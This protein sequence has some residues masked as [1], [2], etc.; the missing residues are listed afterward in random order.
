MVSTLTSDLEYVAS[1]NE[2]G[3]HGSVARVVGP[4]GDVGEDTSSVFSR[5]DVYGE[6][7]GWLV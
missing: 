3:G 6:G 2:F 5:H 4:D 7:G 1:D